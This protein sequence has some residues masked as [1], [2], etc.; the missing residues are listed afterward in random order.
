MDQ[1]FVGSAAIAAGQLTR[2]ALRSRFV[3]VHKDI[4]LANDAEVTAALRAKACWLR[5]RGRGALAGYSASALHG[6]KWIDA[7][8]P[9]AIIDTNRRPV[10]GIH[11]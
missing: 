9:A 2:H 10:Q 1:P 5:S 11:V 4:Y 7:G 8:R 3:A 6:A